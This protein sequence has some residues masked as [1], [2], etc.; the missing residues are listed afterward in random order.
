[1]KIIF[2]FKGLLC[3]AII[4]FLAVSVINSAAATP[5]CQPSVSQALQFE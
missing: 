2:L 1:M 4:A 3:S 5:T